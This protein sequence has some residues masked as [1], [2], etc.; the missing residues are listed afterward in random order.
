MVTRRTLFSTIAACLGAK[1]AKD[2]LTAA[3]FEDFARQAFARPT[4]SP[5]ILIQSKNAP[6]IELLNRLPKA[7]RSPEIDWWADIYSELTA[8]HERWAKEEKA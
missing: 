1:P 2:T 7:E 5:L 4:Q 6:L 3:K 8:I